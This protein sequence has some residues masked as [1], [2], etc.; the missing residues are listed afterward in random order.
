MTRVWPGF[1]LIDPITII[2]SPP[3]CHCSLYGVWPPSVL[4]LAFPASSDPV[5][6]RFALAGFARLLPPRCRQG[7]GSG[8]CVAC[9]F[10]P[11]SA[12]SMSSGQAR[13]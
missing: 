2:D 9:S 11:F 5:P 8:G 13:E 10:L 6:D 7:G 12:W 3:P 4:L 1:R